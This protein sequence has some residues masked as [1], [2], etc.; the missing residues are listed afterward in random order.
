MEYVEFFDSLQSFSETI[1]SRP[2]NKPFKDY[3]RDDLPSMRG[4]DHYTKF[5]GTESFAEADKLMLGG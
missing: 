3:Y 5:S 2:T 1:N 4:G